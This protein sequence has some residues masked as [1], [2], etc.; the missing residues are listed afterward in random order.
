VLRDGT[1][2][3]YSAWIVFLPPGPLSS[4]FAPNGQDLFALDFDFNSERRPNIA[5][6]NNPSA[7]PDIAGQAGRF[8]RIVKRAAA[9]IP[10]KR[11]LCGLKVVLRSQ[12]VEVAHVFKLAGAVGCLLRISPIA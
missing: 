4:L 7:D 12:L 8:Q 9:R 11:M 3:G 5:A 6:L 2:P 10:N 1:L